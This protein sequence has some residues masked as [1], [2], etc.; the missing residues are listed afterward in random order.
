[1]IKKRF[2]IAFILFFTGYAGSNSTG[3]YLEGLKKFKEKKDLEAIK[4]FINASYLSDSC[5]LIFK[6]QEIS[7]L[8][9]SNCELK[10]GAS[11][12][13]HSREFEALVYY[14]VGVLRWEE[15]S[16]ELLKES[17][18]ILPNHHSKAVFE[19]LIKLYPESSFSDNAHFE[20]LKE[21]FCANWNNYPDCGILEIRAY[22]DFLS[23]YPQ[24]ELRFEVEYKRAE[25]YFKVAKLYLNGAGVPNPTKA[26]LFRSQS[27]R[28][29]QKLLSSNAPEQLKIKTNELLRHL[30]QN[31]PRPAV[32]LIEEVVNPDYY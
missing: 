9:E 22:E 3:F 20:L 29:C 2:T 8:P 28:I 7:Q 4:L 31:F 15:E 17:G 16:R 12:S 5:A 24:T 18:V 21:K 11:S 13:S 30:E 27:I 6:N 10:S 32:S 25:T 26:D 1:M 14:R 23:R 19:E